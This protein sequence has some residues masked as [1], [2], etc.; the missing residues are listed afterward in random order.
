[1]ASSYVSSFIPLP[2]G[3]AHRRNTTKFFAA[4]VDHPHYHC[5]YRMSEDAHSILN[6]KYT[7]AYTIATKGW[8]NNE[9]SSMADVSHIVPYP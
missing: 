5:H 4:T 3:C 2:Q 8:Q 1:M 6:R 9:F 7:H